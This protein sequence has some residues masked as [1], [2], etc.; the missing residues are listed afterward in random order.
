MLRGAFKRGSRGSA[1]NVED[2][3]GGTAFVLV[4]V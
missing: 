1:N 2:F 4:I 3:G